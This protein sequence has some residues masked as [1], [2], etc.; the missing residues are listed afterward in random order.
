M[1]F[2]CSPPC[3]Q[4]LK[5]TNGVTAPCEYCK[6]EQVI[7]ETKRID[8]KELNFCSEGETVVKLEGV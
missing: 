7:K 1:L 6:V 8:G 5:E 4:V 2:A 3:A